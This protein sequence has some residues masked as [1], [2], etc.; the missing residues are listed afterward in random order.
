MDRLRRQ[1]LIIFVRQVEIPVYL[2]SSQMV[3]HSTV[4]KAFLTSSVFL[5][6]VDH[7]LRCVNCGLIAEPYGTPL[8]MIAR[9]PYGALAKVTLFFIF[10]M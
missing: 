1:L 9:Y 5:R 3:F 10:V 8:F 7:C 2:A 4:L 6:N